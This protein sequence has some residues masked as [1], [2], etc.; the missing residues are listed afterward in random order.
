MHK[1]THTHTQREREREREKESERN[2]HT[3]GVHE[4]KDTIMAK[5][6]FSAVILLSL[7]K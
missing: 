1:H 7:S 3:P 6:A 2:T 4:D 5:I